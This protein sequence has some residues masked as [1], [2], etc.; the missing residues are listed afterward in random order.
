MSGAQ[1]HQ[2]A[3]AVHRMFRRCRPCHKS[4]SGR[5]APLPLIALCFCGGRPQRPQE[6][7]TGVLDELFP[8]PLSRYCG[9]MHGGGGSDFLCTFARTQPL[10]KSTHE[11]TAPSGGACAVWGYNPRWV[12][13]FS[14]TSGWSIKAMMRMAPAQRGHSSQK[15]QRVGS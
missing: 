8:L 7:P 9:S 10:A 4:R 13:M 5:T 1:H 12:R 2:A 15:I 6:G 3:F 14:L 11:A